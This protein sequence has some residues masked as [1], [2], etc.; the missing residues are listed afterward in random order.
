MCNWIIS[1][2]TGFNNSRGEFWEQFLLF[3][4]D[5]SLEFTSTASS[6][7]VFFPIKTLV[8]TCM[9]WNSMSGDLTSLGYKSLWL[10]LTHLQHTQK[11]SLSEK[12]TYP[13]HFAYSFQNIALSLTG[14]WVPNMCQLEQ[15]EVDIIHIFVL[16]MSKHAQMKW[17][18]I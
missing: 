14:T 17:A 8:Y 7:V 11:D 10:T 13:Q 2:F 9:V 18:E 12:Y 5:D 4:Q 16:L 1:F 6:H 15:C 3:K